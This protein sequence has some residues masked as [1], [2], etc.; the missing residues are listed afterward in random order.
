MP[1]A[2]QDP[3]GKKFDRVSRLHCHGVN[4]DTDL[5]FD[6]N[7]QLYPMPLNQTFSLVLAR[8]L[9]EDGTTDDGV[10]RLRCF[11]FF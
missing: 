2:R 10:W 9:H 11:D 4:Y 3:D 6:V 5:L 1:A 7:T 8:S